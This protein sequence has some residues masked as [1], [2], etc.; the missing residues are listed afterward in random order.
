M[1]R[2]FCRQGIL[3]VN[4]DQGSPRGSGWIRGAWSDY[5]GC[6]RRFVRGKFERTGV[7][8]LNRRNS[9]SVHVAEPR[10]SQLLM[11]EAKQAASGAASIATL[12]ETRAWLS[13]H[14]PHCQLN[15]SY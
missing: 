13:G 6:A 12:P 3:L 14:L 11:G 9:I 5:S 15:C 4:Q 8:L 10:W 1:A 7:A 2:R